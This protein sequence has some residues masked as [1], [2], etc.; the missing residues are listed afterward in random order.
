MK[1]LMMTIA[2]LSTAC[3][4][5]TENTSDTSIDENKIGGCKMTGRFGND[6]VKYPD[7]QQ[8]DVYTSMCMVDFP[9]NECGGQRQTFIESGC[10][11]Q[12][13]TAICDYP[14][15]DFVFYSDLDLDTI[16]TICA[17]SG[18]VF[19]FIQHPQ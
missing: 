16:S 19:N 7:A 6:P 8:L 15:Y 5:S 1:V 2:L 17:E 13:R 11:E 4:N 14:G 10:P 9:K 12:S 3:S 18:G